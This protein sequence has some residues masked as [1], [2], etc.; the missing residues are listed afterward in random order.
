VAALRGFSGKKIVSAVLML[1]VMFGFF[2]LISRSGSGPHS[3]QELKVATAANEVALDSDPPGA[4]VVAET[5]GAVLGKTPLLFLVPPGSAASVFVLSSSREPL[6]VTLPERGGITAKLARIEETECEIKLIAAEPV[7]LEGVEAEI[8]TGAV[9]KIPGAA[10]VRAKPGQRLRGARLVLCPSLGGTKEQDLKLER[11]GAAVAVR[12][13]QPE[14][15]TAYLNGDP[16]GTL[17]ATAEAPAGFA[18]IQVA[19]QQGHSVERWVALFAPTEVRMPAPKQRP[20]P[21]LIAPD[22]EESPDK[23]IDAATAGA[24]PTKAA[25]DAPK[26]GL[27]KAQRALRAKQLSKT[28]AKLLIAGRTQKAK[29]VLTECIQLDPA[30]AECHKS[31]GT[32]YRRIRST[33]KAREHFTRYLELAPGAP[34]AP[35]IRKMLEQ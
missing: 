19:D 28:G 2:A 16:L 35:R 17:P 30:S 23:A 6:R 7:D 13:T 26:P 10:L 8:G 12:M 14:G 1:L 9:R 33:H 29:D 25:P 3:T 34:D 15:E 22:S 20:V 4:T 32:L 11:K 27:S 31:L 18:R 21:V 24:A 5:D